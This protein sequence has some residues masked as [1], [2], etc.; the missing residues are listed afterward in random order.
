MD[1]TDQARVRRLRP[2]DWTK[3]R[4][5][6]LESLASDPLAFGSTLDREAAYPEEKWRGWAARGSTESQEATFVAETPDGSLVGLAGTFSSDEGPTIWGM[7]VRPSWR[8]RGIGGALLEALLDW[9]DQ[10]PPG[11]DVVLEVNPDQVPAVQAY[12]ARGFR[13]SGAERP[14]GHHPPAIVKRMVRARS[15]HS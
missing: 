15:R 11:A 1:V 12:L 3:F 9:I 10:G 2:D 7:W 14:L 6:R 13:F 8:N 4:A 5:L